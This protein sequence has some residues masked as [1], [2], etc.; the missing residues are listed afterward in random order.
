M[1]KKNQ[2][3]KYEKSRPRKPYSDD[4]VLSEEELS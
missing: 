2:N 4:I 1:L 3:K